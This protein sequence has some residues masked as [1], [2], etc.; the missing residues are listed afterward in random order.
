MARSGGTVVA[1][2]I[3]ALNHVRLFSEIHPLGNHVEYLNVV[4]QACR[5]YGLTSADQVAAK[6]PFVEG[7]QLVDT[8]CRQAGLTMVLRDW[9]SI[10]FVGRLLVEDPV[11]H[12]TLNQ[13]LEPY[14]EIREIALVR[15][16]LDLWLSTRRLKVYSGKL[17]SEQFFLGYRHYVEQSAGNFVRYEDFTQDPVSA[18]GQICQQL[19][20]EFDSGFLDRWYLNDNI[21][22]DNKK[23]SRGS[24]GDSAHIIRPLERR[25]VEDEL[26]Q[27][28]SQNLDYQ[29]IKSL[30]GY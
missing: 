3:G 14:F 6:S 1:K 29:A 7:V 21:T 8:A 19:V 25:G 11:Y 26:T 12:F 27:Q 20:M 28:L 16:P 10:D 2:C 17:D 30:L 4:D 22:G 23:S 13:V 5:W 15:D 18:M 9:A 24:Q